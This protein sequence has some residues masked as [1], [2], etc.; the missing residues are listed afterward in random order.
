MYISTRFI[1]LTCFVYLSC[2]VSTVWS[3]TVSITINGIDKTLLNNVNNYLSLETEKDHPNLS[4]NR[5]QLLFNES[6]TEI[7]QALQPFGYYHP[8]IKRTL[9][10]GGEVGEWLATFDIDAGNPTTLNKVEIII[11]GEA[12]YQPQIQ[13]FMAKFPIKTGD[14]LVHSVYSDAKKKLLKLAKQY[15]YFSAKYSRHSLHVRLK[16]QQ[17]DLYLTLDSGERYR[18]A[19]IDFKE[20]KFSSDFLHRFI[21]FEDNAYY[22]DS[23]LTALRNNL[24]QSDYFEEVNLYVH[25]DEKTHLLHTEANLVLRKRQKYRFLLGYG[26][27]TQVRVGADAKVRYLNRYGH[28]LSAKVRM[29]QYLNEK[30]F[31]LEY[32]IPTGRDTDNLFYLKWEYNIFD[33]EP[34]DFGFGGGGKATENTDSSFSLH[35]RHRRQFLGLN[36][37]EDISVSYYVSSYD[38]LSNMSPFLQELFTEITPEY[39]P[40]LKANY[41]LLIP[42]VGWTYRH[43]NNP[44]YPTRGEKFRIGFKGSQSGF[45]SNLSF[46][47][48]EFEGKLIRPLSKKSRFITRTRIAYTQAER[49]DDLNA[50]L[51][52][53][54]FYYSTGGDN[55]V[56][57]YKFESLQGASTWGDQ[58]LFNA[59]IEYDYRF[60]EKWSVATFYDTGNVFTSYSKMNLKHTVG[61][62]LHWLS[63]VGMVRLDVGFP[64]NSDN[65]SYRIHLNIGPD[66]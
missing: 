16:Q 45:I 15:G 6:E 55:S 53:L 23:R 57:G 30:D 48:A 62:G 38:I 47:Q 13:K 65:D 61:V 18:F 66:F 40:V 5:I 28:Y 50:L 64:L 52:P 34:F 27:D 3:D 60:K 51:L 19:P 33:R 43:E 26:T 42:A 31:S 59:S 4:A 24:S 32:G 54:K 25:P 22:S 21:P 29:Q 58:H 9:K 8:E 14:K 2:P 17:A 46:W 56:R 7:K 37:I 35:K 49:I 63:P 10:K 12:R 1:I 44:T 39:L 11:N 41:R 36:L 20:S